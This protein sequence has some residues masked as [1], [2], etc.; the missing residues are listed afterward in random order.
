[1][2]RAEFNTCR[3]VGEFYLCD[4][5]LVVT[6]A[7]KL[8]TAPPPWKDPALCLLALFARQFTL[9]R[10]TCRTRIGGTDSAMRMVSPNLFGSYAGEAHRGLVTC[11]GDEPGKLDTK[12]FTVS[13]LSKITLTNGCSAET[14]TH[15][16]TAADDGFDRA[17]TDYIIGLGHEK[18]Q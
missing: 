7:P 15:I 16:F 18:V 12:S 17:E 6:K 2:T 13:G 1:M 4:R 10:E 14:D 5:G 9:A 11:H 3:R 8:D